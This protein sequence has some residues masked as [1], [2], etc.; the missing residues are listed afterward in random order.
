MI[1]FKKYKR[2]SKFSIQNAN[3]ADFDL[4]HRDKFKVDFHTLFVGNSLIIEM[5]VK[6]FKKA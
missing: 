1:H 6:N 4:F 3:S 5:H 2:I